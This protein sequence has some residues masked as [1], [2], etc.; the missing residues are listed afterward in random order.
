MRKKIYNA[1]RVA[2]LAFLFIGC[3]ESKR[4]K[5]KI[6]VDKTPIAD[7][8]LSDLA[9]D[10]TLKDLTS[11]LEVIW[12]NTEFDTFNTTLKS[13]DLIAQ[14]DSAAVITIFAPVNG[15]FGRITES[16]LNHLL[17]PDG[18]E[19]MTHLLKY[20][21]VS[22]D[23]YDYE[24]LT[25]TVK[26]NDGILRLQTLNGGY[27]ALSIE[28]DELYITDETGF[29]SKVIMPDLEASNGVVHGIE[30]VLLPQ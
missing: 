7:K 1:V 10:A 21:M 17:S 20:H 28:A 13:A 27:L 8:K 11:V 14:I 30:A 24:T 9:P 19:E 12:D 6:V 25:S 4:K 15:A 2:F 29:Q 5:E 18:K 23:E 22:G 26:L 16:K 3:G